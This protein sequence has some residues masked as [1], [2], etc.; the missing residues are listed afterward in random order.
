MSAEKE[1]AS[2]K[3]GRGDQAEE[4]NGS[5]DCRPTVALT[6]I[7]STNT[8]RAEST[9]LKIGNDDGLFHNL[10]FT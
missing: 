9:I 1:A 5:A 10:M 8:E 2:G 7:A 4:V 6:Q 3:R